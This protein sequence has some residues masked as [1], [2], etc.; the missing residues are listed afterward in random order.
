M[1]CDVL[2]IFDTAGFMW[3]RSS[4]LAALDRHPCQC[5][6]SSPHVIPA[7]SNDGKVNVR[8]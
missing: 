3:G 1:S 7:N 6:V 5:R 2:Y 4:K 8:S